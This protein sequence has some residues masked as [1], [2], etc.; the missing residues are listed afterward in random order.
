MPSSRNGLQEARFSHSAVAVG[1]SQTDVKFP[2]AHHIERN[3]KQIV[4]IAVMLA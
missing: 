1:L 2:E 3:Q 4:D